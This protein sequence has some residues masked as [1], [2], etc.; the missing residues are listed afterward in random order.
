MIR[1]MW[2]STGQGRHGKG[3]WRRL[4]LPAA[5]WGLI[6]VT[7]LSALAPLGPPLSR[8]KGSAFNPATLDVVLKARA[9]VAPQAAE[10]VRPDG[11]GAPPCMAALVLGVI[12]L[13]VWRVR[14]ASGMSHARRTLSPFAFVRTRRAR[15]P[16]LPS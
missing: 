2:Q 16:P 5:L 1:P 12:L 14:P 10:A 8:A 13:A 3:A 4:S 7:L 9:Q 11:D 15:A 6:V